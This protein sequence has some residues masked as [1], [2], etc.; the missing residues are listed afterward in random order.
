MVVNYSRIINRYTLFDTYPLPK[1]H[2]IIDQIAKGSVYSTLDLKSTYYQIPLSPEDCPYTAFEVCGKLYQ[3]TRL[4]FSVSNGVSFFQQ[5]VHELI[6][7]YKFSGTFA[8]LD[9]ITVSSVNKND[10]GIL[11]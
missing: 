1:I 8:Y 3:Y 2:E 10:H 5:L 9:N 4:A 11:N 6:E 7:K